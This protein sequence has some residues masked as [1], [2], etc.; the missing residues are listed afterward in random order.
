MKTWA[1][2]L[3]DSEA[4]FRQRIERDEREKRTRFD[5]KHTPMTTRLSRIINAMPVEEKTKPRPISFFTEAL[6][7]KYYG[8]RAHPGEVGRA[9]TEL[10]WIRRRKWSPEKDSRTL[11]YP[12]AST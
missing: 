7:P 12:S 8:A 6:A 1:D 5:A 4:R 11:W 2:Q 10:G 9:L 3:T